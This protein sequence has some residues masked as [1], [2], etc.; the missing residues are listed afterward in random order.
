MFP[1]GSPVAGLFYPP[2]N[3]G[4]I[5]APYDDFEKARVVILPV[6]YDSTT[7]WKS[8]SRDGPKAIIDSSQYIELYDFE[9]DREP[10]QVGIYTAPEVQP[11]MSSPEGMVQSVREITKHLIDRGKLVAMLGGEHLLSLGSIQAYHEA[12]PDLTVLQLDAHT[13]LRSEYLGA[14]ITHA[15]V[16]RQVLEFCPAVQVGM[17]SLS[18][19]ENQF[20]KERKLEIFYAHHTAFNPATIKKIVSRLKGKVYITVDADVFDLG[21]VNAVGTPEPGGLS[22]YEVISILEAVTAAREVV[23]FDVV[24]LCPREG[25]ST[26]AFVL[27]RLV[28]KLIGLCCPPT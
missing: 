28:Y 11:V 4:A 21:L 19:D 18:A 22:W 25:T 13:D 3:F 7:D 10:Y 20:I 15:S 26:S 16:M 5:P 27:A 6:P 17:R 8:G 24:E 1:D 14:T 12:Y 2:Y 23:G 9:M